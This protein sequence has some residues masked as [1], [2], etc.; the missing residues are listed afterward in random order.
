MLVIDKDQNA[1]FPDLVVAP[2]IAINRVN[3]SLTGCYVMVRMLIVG[4][5]RRPYSL[6]IVPRLDKAVARQFVLLMELA[7][8]AILREELRLVV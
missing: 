4:G 7:K 1:R 2:Q 5:N 8:A 3:E 6:R